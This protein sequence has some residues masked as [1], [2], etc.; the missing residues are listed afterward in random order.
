MKDPLINAWILAGA[1]LTTGGSAM[2]DTT[3]GRYPACAK[4]FWLEDMVKFTANGNETAYNNWINRGKCIELREGLDVEIIRFYGDA[5][6]RRVEFNINGY[7]FFT[8]R[9]A[10]AQAL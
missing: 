1:L 5:E 8:V 6:H 7:R 3:T 9:E 4:P 2:A 10:I